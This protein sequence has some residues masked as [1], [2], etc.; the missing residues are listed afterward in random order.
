[1]ISSASIVNRTL[2]RGTANV[3]MQTKIGIYKM[4]YTQF[5]CKN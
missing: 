3:F 5:M 1:M 4:Q 2:A